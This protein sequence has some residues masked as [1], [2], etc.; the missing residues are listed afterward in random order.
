MKTYTDFK[1]QVKQIV[2]YQAVN[3]DEYDYE[4]Y[5]YEKSFFNAPH[6]FI[7][8]VMEHKTEKVFE[9]IRKDGFYWNQLQ[10]KYSGKELTSINSKITFNPPIT[11]QF[12]N[13]TQENRTVFPIPLY[14]HH[15]ID[16]SAFHM[17]G[18]ACPSKGGDWASYPWGDAGAGW[19]I[20]YQE[21][22]PLCDGLAIDIK[23]WTNLFV[24]TWSDPKLFLGNAGLGGARV[25]HYKIDGNVY[26]EFTDP[27]LTDM[28]KENPHKLV[29]TPDGKIV[30]KK[31]DAH[32]KVIV[33]LEFATEGILHDFN[34]APQLGLTKNP[35]LLQ[36]CP[37]NCPKP[38]PC[39]NDVMVERPTPKPVPAP[40]PETCTSISKPE[41]PKPEPETA[42]PEPE[43]PKPNPDTKSD[44]ALKVTYDIAKKVIG[45]ALVLV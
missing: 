35:S 42:K 17:N 23:L 24:E 9:Y 2:D 7:A 38:M 16:R 37:Q 8:I 15:N 30:E 18:G 43:T 13:G 40:Q 27:Y 33:P 41:P 14:G 28:K 4:I 1:N 31:E 29:L 22:T 11:V 34:A 45:L 19:P 20:N 5:L 12:A 6:L 21:I 44:D 39:N 3:L 25:I 32:K 26:G 10:D 36:Y